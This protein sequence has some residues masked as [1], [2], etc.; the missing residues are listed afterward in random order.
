MT[1]GFFRYL[2]VAALFVFT[3]LLSPRS[4]AQG[5]LSNV[6][7]KKIVLS[8]DTLQLDSLS[9]VPGSLVLRKSDGTLLLPQNIFVVD[10]INGKVVVPKSSLSSDTLICTYRVFPFKINAAVYK[11]DPLKITPNQQTIKQLN[12]SKKGTEDIFNSGGLKKAGSISRGISFGNNQDLTVNSNLNLQLSGKIYDDI[13]VLA[14]ITDNNIPIQAEG[15]TQQLQEFDKVYIQFKKNNTRLLTGDFQIQETQDKFLRFNKKAQ[16]LSF[17]SEYFL[18]ATKS[19]FRPIHKFDVNAALSKG[20][21]SRYQLA[22]VEGNQGPYKL[23]GA[24]NESFIIILSGTEKIYVDGK[25]L[26]RGQDKDYIIDYNNAEVTFT[27]QQL[28]TKDKRIIVEF[29]Y[30]DKNYTRTLFHTHQ[31]VIFENLKLNFNL[32]SEQ[33]VRDQQLQQKLNPAQ[34]SILQNVGDS[35]SMALSDNVDSTVYSANYV[36]YKK[37]DTIVNSISYHV[38]VYSVDPVN[39]KYRLVFSDL[40]QGHGNYILNSTSV[41][42]RTYK[43]VAPVG[44]VAQGR[45][46]PKSLLITPKQRQM[47]TV[48]AQY[49]LG[50]NTVFEAE[51]A[52][53]NRN[54]NT[55]SDKDKSDDQGVALQLRFEST[56]RM[57]SSSTA[58]TLKS[59][60][61]YQM[62]NKNFSAIERFRSTEFERD[63][64]IA[65]LSNVIEDEHF[66]NM[67][68]DLRKSPTKFVNVNSSFFTKGAFY[69]GYNVSSEANYTNGVGTKLVGNAS[70]LQS[71]G[72]TSNTEFLRYNS[73]LSQKVGKL[74][75]G[76][77]VEEDNDKIVNALNDTL[78]QSSFI[79]TQRGA[80][81]ATSEELKNSFTLSYDRRNDY[82]T[83]NNA[84]SKSTTAD[85]FQGKISFAQNKYVQL[86][87]S[88]VYRSLSIV[89][90]TLSTVKTPENT[91]LNKVDLTINAFRGFINTRT[92]YEFGSGLEIKREFSYLQ[93]APGQGTYA[94]IDYNGD[95]V[96]Q[97][98][99]F[100]IA[101]FSDDMRF[102]KVYTPTRDFVKSYSTQFNE[103]LNIQ[104]SKLY[105]SQK[106]TGLPL[107]ISKFHN[108]LAYRA[109]MKTNKSAQDQALVPYSRNVAD[110]SLVSTNSSLRNTIFF[111][112][113]N[114]LYTID[115]TYT[116]NQ[117]KTL[118][119]NGFESRQLTSKV[120][121]IRWNFSNKWSVLLNS[122]EQN[123]GK[124]S[125]FFSATDYNIHAYIVNPKLT[126]QPNNNL[127]ATIL[128]N[129]KDKQNAP[130]YGTEK[131]TL[132][133]LGTEVTYNFVGKGRMDLTFNYI[134]IAYNMNTENSSPLEFEMLEGLHNGTNFTWT[135]SI[136][137]RFANNMQISLNYQ[138]RASNK[139]TPVHTGG[140]QVQMLF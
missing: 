132:N 9:L 43:W 60:A 102:I 127:R 16:G 72:N 13:E 100:E 21:F 109:V 136:Q 8:A 7:V 94:W 55:F 95:N 15:N 47:A 83:K 111:N 70:W 76:I 1:Q 113:G 28:I 31:E 39:A 96:Q 25:L 81:V 80:Y 34:I 56:K 30:S 23:H 122:E 108:Q 77:K 117:N 66:G 84:F 33:D 97:L 52:G 2:S 89:D 119:T 103:V 38:F 101:K 5:D 59:T 42:G 17:S 67:K 99:E 116:D 120:L 6:R 36:L 71:F 105:K 18:P 78:L 115:F 104:F 11:K 44:G 134:G 27:A 98:N 3:F 79:Y 123:K 75:F 51:L 137:N 49:Q 14:A 64:N 107:F 88:S 91:L 19:G 130:A 4:F 22:G 37:V 118:L 139:N 86:T 133:Q 29:Q 87:L 131:T 35:L 61:D 26:E 45:Y 32:Y 57:D 114:P 121:N 40:G 54:L 12:A 124:F 58:W 62:V 126:F 135:V 92:Y 112:R 48:S 129:Y 74:V 20:K 106:L 138:G 68:F 41:N 82:A 24:E 10:Y 46:E 140:V 93:V 128:Y 90:S 125:Q 110:T 69:K 50:K 65:G 53:S 63:W 73:N 85:N